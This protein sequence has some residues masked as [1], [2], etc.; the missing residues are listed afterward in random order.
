MVLPLTR[1]RKSLIA[2][3]RPPLGGSG[4][5]LRPHAET[6]KLTASH[7]M[8][9]TVSKDGTRIFPNGILITIFLIQQFFSGRDG[10]DDLFGGSPPVGA[11]TVDQLPECQVVKNIFSN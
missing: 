7:T 2:G 8:A 5:P 4:G 3:G 10:P 1:Y 9:L 6:I 11:P